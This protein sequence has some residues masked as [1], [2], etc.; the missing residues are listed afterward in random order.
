[1]ATLAELQQLRAALVVARANGI[2]EVRDSSGES[3]AYKSDREMASALA[4]LDA[5]IRSMGASRPAFI[6]F[7]TSKGL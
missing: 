4:A 6:R 3:I 1:M 7:Q 5:E 2:R